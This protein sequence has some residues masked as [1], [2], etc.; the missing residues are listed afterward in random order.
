MKRRVQ[1]LMALDTLGYQYTGN[2]DTSRMPDTEVDD[3][4]IVE[5]LGGS[6]KICHRT[7][8]AQSQSTP[9][10]VRRTRL[11]IELVSLSTHCIIV[12]E[13]TQTV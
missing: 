7:H 4:D 3:D 2:D 10:L 9:R 11:V 6:S 12:I 13:L 1:P 5:R 8:P